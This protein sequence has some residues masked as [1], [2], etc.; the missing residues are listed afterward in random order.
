MSLICYSHKDWLWDYSLYYSQGTSIIHPVLL[1][2]NLLCHRAIILDSIIFHFWQL[3]SL[4]NH[5][6]SKGHKT[7]KWLSSNSPLA[8]VFSIKHWSFELTFTQSF[9]LDS[10][11]RL[12]FQPLLEN[13]QRWWWVHIILERNVGYQSLLN[14]AALSS[15]YIYH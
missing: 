1:Q 10:N 6:Y 9:I 11:W 15:I 12:G 3:I 14:T 4:L 2:S 8:I 5:I 13:S 7:R